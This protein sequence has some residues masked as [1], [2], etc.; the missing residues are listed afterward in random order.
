MF[1][2]T[3]GSVSALS[4]WPRLQLNEVVPTSG[5]TPQGEPRVEPVL[6]SSQQIW[7]P[8]LLI[9]ASYPLPT[10]TATSYPHPHN[11]PSPCPHSRRQSKKKKKK[12]LFGPCDYL[13]RDQTHPTYKRVAIPTSVVTPTLMSTLLPSQGDS[14]TLEICWVVAERVATGHKDVIMLP[15]QSSS[16][17]LQTKSVLVWGS[18]ILFCSLGQSFWSRDTSQG[19]LP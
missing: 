2:A 6:L 8:A 5:R 10:H 16:R 13:T 1:S 15:L 12:I 11:L 18:K 7:T 19:L 3:L 9:T 14:L 17:Y 4:Y